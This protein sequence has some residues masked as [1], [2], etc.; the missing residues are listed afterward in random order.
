MVGRGNEQVMTI[1][2]SDPRSDAQAPGGRS[3]SGVPSLIVS[4]DPATG[5]EN[6]SVTTGTAE[7]VASGAAAA[8]A[9]LPGWRLTAPGARGAALRAA[10][11]DLRADADRVAELH[12]RDTGRLLSDAR[13]AV[14]GAASLL[15]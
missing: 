11:A 2:S 8:R 13:G 6:G 9:A 3:D 14:E 12:M 10:A 15:E 1:V 4:V 7:D 5:A